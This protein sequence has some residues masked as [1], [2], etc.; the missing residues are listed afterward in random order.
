MMEVYVHIRGETQ[1]NRGETTRIVYIPVDTG[2]QYLP[3]IKDS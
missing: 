2:I 1:E 3:V